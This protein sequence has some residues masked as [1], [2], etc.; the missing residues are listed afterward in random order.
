MK[1]K[2][3]IP[4]SKLYPVIVEDSATDQILSET[5]NQIKDMI[6]KEK[7]LNNDSTLRKSFNRRTSENRLLS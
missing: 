4:A 1:T 7:H 3:Y 5:Y 6:R 2:S